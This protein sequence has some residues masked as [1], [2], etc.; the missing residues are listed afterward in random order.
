[1]F[2]KT[3][4]LKSRK[5]SCYA[6]ENLVDPANIYFIYDLFNDALSS[7]DYIQ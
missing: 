1:M 5:E 3:G 7:S 2:L 6:M 4:M